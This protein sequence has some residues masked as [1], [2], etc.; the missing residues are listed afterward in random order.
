MRLKPGFAH[1]RLQE[2]R[3]R[4]LRQEHHGGVN[5]PDQLCRLLNRLSGV[6]DP[7]YQNGTAGLMTQPLKVCAVQEERKKKRRPM[8]SF[9]ELSHCAL[10]G[11]CN[12]NIGN[13]K[14]I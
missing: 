7:L 1:S 2:G 6:S 14:E 4:S 10:P 9:F 3:G 8:Y 11:L 13:G 12:G 5:I